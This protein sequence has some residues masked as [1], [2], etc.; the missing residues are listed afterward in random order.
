MEDNT[1]FLRPHEL[2]VLTGR[3][4]P[5]AQIE[6]LRAHRIRHMVNAAGRPVV[7]KAWLDIGTPKDVPGTQPNFAAARRVA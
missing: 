7:A 2:Q 5:K 6:F 1:L 4:R 3:T